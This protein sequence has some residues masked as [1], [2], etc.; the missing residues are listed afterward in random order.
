MSGRARVC[1]IEALIRLLS[2]CS[3]RLFAVPK[4]FYSTTKYPPDIRKKLDKETRFKL[5]SILLT[6]QPDRKAL[7]ESVLKKEGMSDKEAEEVVND[8]DVAVINKEKIISKQEARVL[9]PSVIFKNI[10]S[11]KNLVEYS[12]N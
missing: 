6:P 1:K 2:A 4:S 8:L 5:L 10:S 7:A 3:E 12:S 9:L 11:G